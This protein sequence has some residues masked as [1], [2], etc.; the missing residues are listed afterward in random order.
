MNHRAGS[1]FSFLDPEH[2][3]VWI[4]TCLFIGIQLGNIN[5]FLLELHQIA[6][7]HIM[8]QEVT[9]DWYRKEERQEI[10]TL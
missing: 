10:V 2:A 1:H 6:V 5:P 4:Q 3:V 8:P 9:T 7:V